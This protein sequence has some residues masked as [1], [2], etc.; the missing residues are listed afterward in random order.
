M[1][2]ASEDSTITEIV[3]GILSTNRSLL[4]TYS[5]REQLTTDIDRCVGLLRT[6]ALDGTGG[7]G[8]ILLPTFSFLSHSCVNNAKHVLSDNG[9]AIR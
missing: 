7:K 4:S 1:D 2:A 6:N 9:D 5:S 3:C 8:R